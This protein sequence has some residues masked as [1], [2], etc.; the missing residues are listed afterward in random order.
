MRLSMTSWPMARPVTGRTLSAIIL[1]LTGGFFVLLGVMLLLAGL[2]GDDGRR[3]AETLALALSGLY[4]L[5]IGFGAGALLGAR[6]RERSRSSSLP[7]RRGEHRA[8]RDHDWDEKE[9]EPRREPLVMVLLVL[10]LLLPF[11]IAAAFAPLPRLAGSFLTV[12]VLVSLGFRSLVEILCRI[13]DRFR[14]RPRLGFGQFPF[15]LG[16]RLRAELRLARPVAS[17]ADRVLLLLRPVE[18]A[19][20]RK[21]KV[22]CWSPLLIS[23]SAPLIDKKTV[24]IDLPIPGDAPSTRLAEPPCIFWELGVRIPLRYGLRMTWFFLVPVYEE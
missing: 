9:A 10:I 18:E 17:A 14:L 12:V 16:G 21:K 6:F 2:L 19:V 4:C 8:T 23:D 13:R 20:S 7:F 22:E 15:P 1:V 24:S 11:A 3:T 5:A